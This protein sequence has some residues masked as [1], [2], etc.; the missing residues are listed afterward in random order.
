M[1][2]GEIIKILREREGWSQTELAKLLGLSRSAVSMW[3]IV[4]SKVRSRFSVVQRGSTW[5]NVVHIGASI[6]TDL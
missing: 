1:T 6:L 3:E 2:S 4:R 5:F